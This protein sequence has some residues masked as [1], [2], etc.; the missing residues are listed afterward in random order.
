MN[1][2]KNQVVVNEVYCNRE[3]VEEHL[4]RKF[5]DEQWKL[6]KDELEGNLTAWTESLELG[7]LLADYEIQK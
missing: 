4:E 6:V 7:A 5:S 2:S 1:D 3:D